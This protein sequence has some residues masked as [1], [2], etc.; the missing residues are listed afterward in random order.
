MTSHS[1]YGGLFDAFRDNRG[2]I[3]YS[4][5][6]RTPAVEDVQNVLIYITFST[7]FLAFLIIFPGIRKEVSL[8]HYINSHN[9]LNN[10]LRGEKESGVENFYKSFA[11]GKVG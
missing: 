8:L 4:D 6:N 5:I 1:S 10:F 2:P 11:H 3:L 9:R 7:L